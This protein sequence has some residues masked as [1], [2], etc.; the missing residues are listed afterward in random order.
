[1]T[2]MS[3]MSVHILSAFVTVTVLKEPV[4][5]YHAYNLNQTRQLMANTRMAILALVPIQRK[6]C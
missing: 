5:I 6:I 2:E 4:I 3:S 1:M